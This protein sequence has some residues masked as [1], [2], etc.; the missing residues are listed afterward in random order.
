VA[1]AAMAGAAGYVFGSLLPGL[2]GV[3]GVRG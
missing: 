1:L 3:A 2:L